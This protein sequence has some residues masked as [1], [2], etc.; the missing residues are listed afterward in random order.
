MFTIDTSLENITEEQFQLARKA[1]ISI[2]ESTLL[3]D[4]EREAYIN[5]LIK[6][7]KREVDSLN[8]ASR[9]ARGGIK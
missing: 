2:T 6:D 8:E 7:L 3:P 4:F 1:G 9:V 5:L